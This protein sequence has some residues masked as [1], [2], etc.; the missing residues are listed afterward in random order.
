M[1]KTKL[2]SQRMLCVSMKY[3]MEI[4]IMPTAN[5]TVNSDGKK[6]ILGRQIAWDL[7]ERNNRK[8]FFWLLLANELEKCNQLHRTNL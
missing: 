4:H 7:T 1:S 3:F 6:N 5:F 2:K 8:K